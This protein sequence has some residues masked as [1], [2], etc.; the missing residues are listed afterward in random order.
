MS[1]EFRE[2]VV[3]TEG[4]P[5]VV[6]VPYMRARRGTFMGLSSRGDARV[7]FDGVKELKYYSLNYVKAATEEE[8]TD[9]H[10]GWRPGKVI[11]DGVETP[12]PPS[13]TGYWFELSD[14]MMVEET[15]RQLY[16]G[17]PITASIEWTASIVARLRYGGSITHGGPSPKSSL[18]EMARTGPTAEAALNELRLAIEHQGWKLR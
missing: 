16:N 11:P 15:E 8:M 1:E 7:M 2:V 4:D 10:E 9:W 14:V 6:R 3:L 13:T 12:T 17:E 18:V 5:V